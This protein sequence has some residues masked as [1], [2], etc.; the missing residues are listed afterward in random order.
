MQRRTTHI[1]AVVTTGQSERL[2]DL[3]VPSS[4]LNRPSPTTPATRRPT[5]GWQTVTG[6]AATTLWSHRLRV[7]QGARRLR[8]RRLR[9]IP[10]PRSHTPHSLGHFSTTTTI[11]SRRSGN[12]GG[13]SSSTHTISLLT[14][15]FR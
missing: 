8:D 4:R 7:A 11:S 12:T 15:G 5:Q 3:G 14:I 1:F 2:R 6:F 13:Q 10:T 9:S